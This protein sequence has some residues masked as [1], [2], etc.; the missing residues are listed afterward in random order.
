MRT[1]PTWS[2]FGFVLALLA[3]AAVTVDPLGWK[4]AG[5]TAIKHVPLALAL[6]FTLLTAVG[7]RLRTPLGPRRPEASIVRATWP[8]LALSVLILVGSL[9]ERSV[10][11]VR[12]TF[13][14]VGLYMV[15]VPVAAYVMCRSEAP[16]AL[17]RACFAV[18]V[19]AGTV[20][21][22]LLV[23]NYRVQQVYHEQIFLV[24]PLAVLF[25]AAPRLGFAGRVGGG[26]FL[27]MTWFSQKYT[28]YIVG[29]VTVAY[30]LGAV[31]L[32]RLSARSALHRLTLA[33]WTLVL[34]L[35]CAALLALLLI[36]SRAELPSGNLDYR[37]H[38]YSNAWRSFVA[39]PLWGTLF[40]A[41]AVRKFTLYDI[42][43]A[44]NRLPTHS[45]VLDLLANGGLIGM[46]LWVL[47]LARVARL[48]ARHALA[49]RLAAAPETPYAHAL[50][51]ISLGGLIT[52][53]VNPVLL[54]P[55]MAFLL[56]TSA[57]LLL[58]IALRRQP[59]VVRTEQL[60]TSGFH[61]RENIN[62]TTR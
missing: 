36:W 28:S 57:G 27:A 51:M 2:E 15:M 55:A 48:A 40:A 33:Y 21:G 52:C 4:L 56:W 61:N 30:L 5:H 35:A 12:D 22:V 25:F 49:P 46:G 6:G 10:S 38:T 11:G 45:D 42:G 32:P 7:H 62:A 14:N 43:V 44:H 3:A 23:A 24:I 1:D 16:V 53:A 41:D 54:Q 17:L 50:A 58:G 29:G 13:L 20:M 18:L 60:R 9:Y 59:R 37:L 34:A 26:F 31:A 47:G 39:S 8:L 19:A